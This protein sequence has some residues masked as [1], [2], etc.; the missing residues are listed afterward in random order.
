MYKM[1]SQEKMRLIKAIAKAK[2]AFHRAME[3]EGYHLESGLGDDLIKGRF[4]IVDDRK[5]PNDLRIVGHITITH[6]L[7]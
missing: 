6:E 5:E 2:N 4:A 1:E 3:A 7:R